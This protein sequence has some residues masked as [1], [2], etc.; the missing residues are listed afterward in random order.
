[1][2]ISVTNFTLNNKKIKRSKK[3][4]GELVKRCNHC[5]G[6]FKGSDEWEVCIMC[7]RPKG[8]ICSN[9]LFTTQDKLIQENT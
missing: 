3:N 1:M 5:G 7:G 6:A 4:N 2:K 9:C 8:H